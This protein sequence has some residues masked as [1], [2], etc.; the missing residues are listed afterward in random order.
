MA[1]KKE[2]KD[3][4]EKEAVVEVTSTV[5][6]QMKRKAKRIKIRPFVTDPATVAVKYGATI[7]SGDYSSARVDVMLSVPCYVEEMLDVYK[8]VRAL[9]E[10]LVDKEVDRVIND[11][12]GEETV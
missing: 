5:L 11:V 6:G 9:C 7:P 12:K 3:I 4:F 1:K 10:K 2:K 8:W